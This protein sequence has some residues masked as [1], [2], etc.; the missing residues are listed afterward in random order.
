L[1]Q[2]I[3]VILW[4]AQRKPVQ[5]SYDKRISERA[6]LADVCSG[7]NCTFRQLLDGGCTAESLAASLTDEELALICVGNV[8]DTGKAEQSGRQLVCVGEGCVE[9][10]TGVD[11][12]VGA[13]DTTRALLDKRLLPNMPMADGGGGIRLLPEFEMDENGKLLTAGIS[14]IKNGERLMTEQE[15]QF[16]A[17]VPKGER[18]WQYTTALSMPVVLAQTWDR[19]CWSRCG[20]IEKMEMQ[21]FGLKLWLAPGMNIHR[22]PLGGRNFEYYSED[23]LLTGLCAATIIQSLQADGTAG[24]T[25]KHMACNNQEENRGGMN[26]HVSERALR[27]IYLKGYEIA[28]RKARPQAIMTGHNLVNGVNAAE[29]CDLLTAA[30]REEWGFDGLVMTDWGTTTKAGQKTKYG[31]SDCDSCIRAGTD[32]IMPGSKEDLREIISAVQS[33][34]LSRR[35]LRWSAWNI[36]RVMQRLYQEVC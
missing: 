19:N 27:E 1:P 23:P 18:Y 9:R 10:R 24:A 13:S 22:N 14:A 16:F 30:S 35:D 34:R 3:P 28:I 17:S 36:L 6:A 32:L 31:P 2:E 20:E 26:A 25:I 11:I 21:R 12:V 15:K 5:H 29:S 33:G 7:E 8:P 4:Q